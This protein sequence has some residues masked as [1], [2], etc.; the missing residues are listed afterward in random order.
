MGNMCN[1]NYNNNASKKL[2][3]SIKSILTFKK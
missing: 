2:A 3:I 1:N